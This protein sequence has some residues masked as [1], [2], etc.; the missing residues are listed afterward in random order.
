[1]KGRVAKDELDA[2]PPDFRVREIVALNVPGLDAE[3]HLV[4]LKRASAG[5]E[6]MD[7]G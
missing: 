2:V 7:R 4:I 5:D 1:M 6:G 3:R